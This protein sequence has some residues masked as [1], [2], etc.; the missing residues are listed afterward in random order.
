M[1]AT[2]IIAVTIFDK[3]I[4]D[5]TI[6]IL[7]TERQTLIDWFDD[8]DETIP[9]DVSYITDVVPDDASF[10]AQTNTANK[11]RYARLLERD[12]DKLTIIKDI[13]KHIKHK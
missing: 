1:M 10:F 12:I 2:A 9:F 5:E 4:I 13:R 6:H 7:E 11:E 8:N 3:P